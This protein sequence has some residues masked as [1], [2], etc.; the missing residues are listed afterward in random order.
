MDYEYTD[1]D[2]KK[3]QKLELMILE[4]IDSI[5]D[6]HNIEYYIYGGTGLGAVRHGGF[7]PWD[8]DIDIAMFRDDYEKLLDIFEDELDSRFHVF[9]FEKQEECFFPFAKICLSNTRFEDWWAKQ[10]SVDEGIF[11]DIFPLDNVPKSKF[12]RKLYH[13]KCR[14]LDHI[15][16][17]AI[18]HIE[19]GSKLANI[20]HKALHSFLN[21]IPISNNR[22]KKMF[23]NSLTKYKDIDTDLVTCYF[24]QITDSHFGKFEYYHKS[25]YAPAKKF[26][27]EN[28]VLLGP[29]DMDTVLRRSYNDYMELPPEDKRVNHAPEVLDFGEY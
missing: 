7:I 1:E 17:N 9:A 21:F 10:V 16:M 23:Y 18:L 19:I 29:N 26:K 3:L 12:K 20:C 4:E 22:W 8:D 2:L 5:C 28:T 24:S 13:Y 14:F 11:V 6:K 25:E 15:V 27:F